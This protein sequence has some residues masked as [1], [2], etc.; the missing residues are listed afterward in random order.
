MITFRF[1]RHLCLV[2]LL[3]CSA[4]QAQFSIKASSTNLLDRRFAGASATV[5][6]GVVNVI[7]VRNGG[8]G[9]ASAPSIVV[10]PPPSGNTA[11][12]TATISGGVVTAITINSGGSG[13]TNVPNITIAPPP[14]Y[15]PPGTPVTTTPQYAGQA[16]TTA[17]SGPVNAAAVGNA[18]ADF[19][20]GR[21]PRGFNRSNPSSP[22][23]T[24]VLGRSSFGNSFASGVPRYSFGDEIPRPTLNWKG[25]TVAE[26]YW[27]IKPVEPGEIFTPAGLSNLGAL[28]S[29]NVPLAAGTV[30]VT[31]STGGSTTVIVASVPD[32]LTPG[33]T[34]LGKQVAYISGTTVTLVTPTSITTSAPTA[35]SFTPR[36]PYYYS[37]HAQRVFA[38]QPGRVTITWVSNLPDTSGLG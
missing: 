31:S 29:G 11:T 19:A 10:S 33:A 14:I 25:D 37:P 16:N 8:A 2:G 17:T 26:S 30:T 36:M 1:L 38:S 28:G 24:V 20:N 15:N 21:F 5:S 32:T 27:R 34:L 12:A 4:V 13:Y 22:T 9:Y 6:G 3:S 35:V 18:I 7:T 23:V